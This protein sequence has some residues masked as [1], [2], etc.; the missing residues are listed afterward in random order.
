MI[1]I[2]SRHK[3]RHCPPGPLITLGD[4]WLGRLGGE[5]A[6]TKRERPVD[7]RV[8]AIVLMMYSGKRKRDNG[9]T[10][11]A[12]ST[13]VDSVD[14][15]VERPGTDKM[16]AN[17]RRPRT[18]SHDSPVVPVR[19]GSGAAGRQ[20]RWA[21]LG[22]EIGRTARQVRDVDSYVHVLVGRGFSPSRGY[23][24]AT[25]CGLLLWIGSGALLTTWPADCPLC[26]AAA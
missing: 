2:F 20:S 22:D 21:P 12:A 9:L 16:S 17:P 3:A 14:M 23:H 4:I 15:R 18:S 5:R 25:E 7:L 1:P 8:W 19:E 6:A 26:R 10:P 11:P 13:T 24:Y